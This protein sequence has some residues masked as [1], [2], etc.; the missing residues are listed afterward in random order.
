MTYI[1]WEN[2]KRNNPPLL[3]GNVEVSLSR[4]YG[5][6][7]KVFIGGDPEGLRSLAKMLLWLAD[8]NQEETG[9]PD[10]EREHIHLSAGS[11]LSGW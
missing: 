10:G 2:M 3:K 4:Y 1:E 11:Q 9:M 7:Q 8:V 6:R 5:N